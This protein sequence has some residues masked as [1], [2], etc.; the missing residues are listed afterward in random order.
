[1]FEKIEKS[2]N[3]EYIICEYLMRS[4]LIFVG[5]YVFFGLVWKEILW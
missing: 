3:I 5:V 1:M 4:F 2:D